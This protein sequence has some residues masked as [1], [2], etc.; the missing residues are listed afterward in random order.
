MKFERLLV[1][2]DAERKDQPALQRAAWLAE[3]TGAELH[4]LLCAFSSSLDHNLFLEGPRLEQAR[5]A[6]LEERRNWLDTLAAPLRSNGGKVHTRVIWSKQRQRAS[7]DAISALQPDLVFKSAHH[8][9]LLKRLLL[10]NSD[11]E[12]LRHCPLPLW[13]VHHGEW[14]GR[15]LCAALDPLHSA[16]KPAALDHRLI[17]VASSLSTQLGLDAHYLHSFAPLPRSLVFDLEMVTDYQQYSANCAR[18]HREAFEQ[19]L[20]AHAIDLQRS[21]LLEG[22]AEQSI[23]AF[24]REQGIDLLV[25]GAVSRSQL[26]S[27]IIGNTAE[28]V[29]EDVEC[30]LLVLKPS[31]PDGT[32]A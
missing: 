17:E 28:R 5:D 1:L 25:M 24:V 13:L 20:A 30:D 29:L 22:F 26:D 8:H 7:L 32:R 6:F 21:H 27:A 14:Q 10:S 3:R 18:R 19:L 31:A 2:I 9:G 12:L 4:L 16:D 11:W 15:R 23:P